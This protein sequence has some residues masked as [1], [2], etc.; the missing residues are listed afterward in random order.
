MVHKSRN[1][2]P[3]V[4]GDR[5]S[6]AFRNPT[7]LAIKSY[8]AQA[9]YREELCSPAYEAT[10]MHPWLSNTHITASGQRQDVSVH[11]EGK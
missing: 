11:A 9:G 10:S 4:L 3:S 5:D 2:E 6:K 1:R 7:L 8:M